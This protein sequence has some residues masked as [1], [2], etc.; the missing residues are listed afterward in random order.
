[1]WGRRYVIGRRGMLVWLLAIW[2]GPAG[3][4]R[5][6]VSRVQFVSQANRVCAESAHRLARLAAPSGARRNQLAAQGGFVDAYVAEMRDELVRLRK[7]GYPPDGRTA[8][9]PLYGRLAIE[10]DL[11][12]RTPMRFRITRLSRLAAQLR[13]YGLTAC[14]T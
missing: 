7:L 14:R 3:C 12:Q 11:A 10:L 1:M 9:E 4:G 5:G 8:L 6:A 2:L 13:G